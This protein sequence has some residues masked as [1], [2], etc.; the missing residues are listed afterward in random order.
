VYDPRIF[1]QAVHRMIFTPQ[2][3]LISFETPSSWV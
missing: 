3:Q 2:N 1:S